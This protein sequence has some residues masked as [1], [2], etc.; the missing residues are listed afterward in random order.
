MFD[1]YWNQFSTGC[2]RHPRVDP[3]WPHEEKA[4]LWLQVSGNDIE[5]TADTY[6]INTSNKAFIKLAHNT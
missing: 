2:P 6:K 3:I 1:K 5:Q 4:R